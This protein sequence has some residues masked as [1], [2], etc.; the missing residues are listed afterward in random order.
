[1]TIMLKRIFWLSFMPALVVYAVMVAWSLPKISKLAGGAM[2]F[3]MRPF[4]YSTEEAVSFLTLLTEEGRKHYLHVQHWLDTG[5]P[6]LLA[7]ALGSGIVVLTPAGLGRWKWLLAF[8]AMP[9]MIFDYAENRLVGGILS[10]PVASVT[11]GMV[12]AASQATI[13]KSVFTTLAMSLFLLLVILWLVRRVKN[14][15]ST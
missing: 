7:V 2:P 12:A 15:T 3:D 1:M 6:V 13:L 4:G 9:G 14:R 10:V 8:V 11:D 5:Y